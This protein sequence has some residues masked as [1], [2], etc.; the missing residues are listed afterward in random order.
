M[1][2][3][4]TIDDEMIRDLTVPKQKVD[5]LALSQQGI[6]GNILPLDINGIAPGF[7]ANG[8]LF[9]LLCIDLVPVR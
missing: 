5:E 9:V 2:R 1:S 6:G 3:S 7:A 8:E 4:L